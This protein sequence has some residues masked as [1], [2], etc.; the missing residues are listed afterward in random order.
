MSQRITRADLRHR[1]RKSRL[2]TLA[3]IVSLAVVL[4]ILLAKEKAD[5][6]YVL[7]TLG[8]TVLL[9]VVAFADL[10]GGRKGVDEAEL[11][12]DA[13]ALGSSIPATTQPAAAASSDWGRTKKLRK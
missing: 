8:V 2:I 10:H 12:D 11:G 5:W 1:K 4:I 7:A 3:W 9:V 6:L 13:A